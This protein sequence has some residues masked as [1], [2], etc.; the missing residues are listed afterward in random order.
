[1][2]NHKRVA[3]AD[4]GSMC[5]RL[6]KRQ[7]ELLIVLAQPNMIMC[8]PGKAATAMIERGLLRRPSHMKSAAVI[9]SAGLRALAD[10]MDAGLVEPTI[11]RMAAEFSARQTRG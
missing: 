1:M 11:E 4:D 8:S 6:G 3:P 7:L 5:M 2:T 9:S 10:A